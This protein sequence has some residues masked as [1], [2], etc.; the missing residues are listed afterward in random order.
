MVDRDRLSKLLARER[1]LFAARNPT[2]AAAHGRAGFLFGRVPMTWM[3]K[4][5]GG[6]P[7]YA[8]E[9][10]GAH[11]T[12]LDGHVYADFSLGDTAAMAGHSP[13]PVVD[14]VTRQLARGAS[15]ML[16]TEDAAMAGAE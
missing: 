8:A 11:L 9:A 15:L 10:R 7:L 1:D 13:A 6:F 5:A 14:A 3:N 16:P 12:D 4:T 2:S